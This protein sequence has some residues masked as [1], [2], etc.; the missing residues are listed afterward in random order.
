MASL[1][2][3]YSHVFLRKCLSSGCY[4]FESSSLSSQVLNVCK[5]TEPHRKGKLMQTMPHIHTRQGLA[6][7]MHRIAICTAVGC[8]TYSYSY[9]GSLLAANIPAKAST[10]RISLHFVVL[11]F[12]RIAAVPRKDRLKSKPSLQE[13]LH[14]C[15]GRQRSLPQS[16]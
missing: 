6:I 15:V 4:Y 10:R 5:S 9:Q 16:F 3:R 11:F 2:F 13:V 12:R 7:Q 14:T 8:A 1:I